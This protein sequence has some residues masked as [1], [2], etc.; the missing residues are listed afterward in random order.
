MTKKIK[1]PSLVRNNEV[2]NIVFT[3]DYSH[4]RDRR[5]AEI[6]H[7]VGWE[8]IAL[9]L[10]QLTTLHVVFIGDEVISGSFPSTF[11]YKSTEAQKERPDLTVRFI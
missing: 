2:T 4:D 6:R 10:P 1:L 9:R 11:T 5:I 3:I 8:I 7:L